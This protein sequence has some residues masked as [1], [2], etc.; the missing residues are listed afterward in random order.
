MAW[1]RTGDKPLS[2]PM[3]VQF[4][5]AYII[6]VTRPQWVKASKRAA[7]TVLIVVIRHPH[8]VFQILQFIPSLIQSPT[9]TV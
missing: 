4:G 9:K 1:R 6:C 3:I 2:E 8:I 5:D 7:T